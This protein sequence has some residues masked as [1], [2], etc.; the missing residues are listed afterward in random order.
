V[1]S[2]AVE[3]EGGKTQADES[4]AAVNWHPGATREAR[5]GGVDTSWI[6][7]PHSEWW[8]VISV[9]GTW[10]AAIGTIAT[11]IIALWLAYRDRRIELQLV[12]TLGNTSFGGRGP[13]ILFMVNNCGRRTMLVDW[14][15]FSV[16][17]LPPWSPVFP[18]NNTPL[19]PEVLARS[20]TLKDGE[21]YQRTEP[22]HPLIVNLA[23]SL[24]APLWLGAWTLRFWAHTSVDKVRSVR[25]SKSLR[26]R[27]LKVA[28]RART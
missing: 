23:D 14:V 27:V 9:L 24:P 10:L 28:R 18:K 26:Q 22:Y 1:D 11:A 4:K 8:N 2:P 17:A 12:A 15:G 13:D 20:H 21:R 19:P 3:Q 6:H 5:E 25:V 7:D 16:G